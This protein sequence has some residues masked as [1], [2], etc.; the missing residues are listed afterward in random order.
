MRIIELRASNFARLNAVEIRPDGAVVALRGKN[1][2]GKSSILKAIWTAFVG[3][4]VAP[5]RAIKDG[6]DEARLRV[7]VGDDLGHTE[8]VIE[9]TIRRE[10]LGGETWDLKVTQG[11]GLPACRV[12][13]LLAFGKKMGNKGGTDQA[14]PADNE[15]GHA[16]ISLY[17]VMV[18]A[19]PV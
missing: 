11:K 7:D 19:C 5:P 13:N 9:R 3:R 15:V 17:S 4:A 6:S 8:L 10:K 14:G 18:G 2:Q 1:T 12:L 16:A